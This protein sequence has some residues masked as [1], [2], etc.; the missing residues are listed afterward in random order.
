[1]L[2]FYNILALHCHSCISHQQFAR[3]T[4]LHGMM[5]TSSGNRNWSLVVGIVD[6]VLACFTVSLAM[7]DSR[8]WK[9]AK[10]HLTDFPDP[11]PI[12][13]SLGTH[14]VKGSSSLGHPLR[15]KGNTI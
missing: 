14:L 9:S 13:M 4:V 15:T 10:V 6:S 8:F 7:V 12:G 1:M 3:N 11:G 5:R 2:V